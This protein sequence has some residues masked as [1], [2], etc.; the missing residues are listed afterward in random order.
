[1]EKNVFLK[2]TKKSAERKL[3]A[4]T[5]IEVIISLAIC[6]I[7]FSVS[8]RF[9]LNIRLNDNLAS[10]QKAELLLSC[11]PDSMEAPADLK[12]P[13]DSTAISNLVLQA[14]TATD[15]IYTGLK[16]I[17]RSVRLKDGRTVSQE[18]FFT[19]IINDEDQ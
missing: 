3:Q 19:R 13:R 14:D 2:F 1:M 11:P 5:L 12:L 8:M 7:I 15:S 16:R 10:K 17:T 18:I 6:L 9:I 4:S